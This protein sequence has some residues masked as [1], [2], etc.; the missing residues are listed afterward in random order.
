MLLNNPAFG[1][2]TIEEL[3]KSIRGRAYLKEPILISEDGVVWNGNRRLAII[4]KLRE[5]EYEVRY[6]KVPVCIL[7]HLDHPDLKALEGRLQV[8]KTYK[9]EYGTIDIRCR[10]RQ[11]RQQNRTWEQIETELGKS[12]DKLKKMDRELGLVNTWMENLGRD[13]D[14][15]MAQRTGIEIFVTA[16]ALLLLN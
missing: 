5:E 6:E 10:V 1:D 8:K 7:P 4:R 16:E 11:A 14:Y 2:Q 9:A 13:T 3:T 15:R 12:I